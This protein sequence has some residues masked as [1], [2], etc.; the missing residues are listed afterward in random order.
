MSPYA[1]VLLVALGGLL[2]VLC[3]KAF[4]AVRPIS[5]SPTHLVLCAVFGVAAMGL[6][7]GPWIDGLEYEDA[8]IHKAFAR[9]LAA[10][11]FSQTEGFFVEVC[12]VGSFHD[13]YSRATFGTQLIGLGVID[14]V[15]VWLFGPHEWTT[16]YASAGAT[17]LSLLLVDQLAIRG[18]ASVHGRF[19]ALLC[20]IL[21]P[22]FFVI[23]ASSFAEPVFVFFILLQIFAY[24]KI[25][26]LRAL[27]MDLGWICIFLF[28]SILL[29]CTK[30]E[31]LTVIL[32][33]IVWSLAGV[34]RSRQMTVRSFLV[35]LRADP[36]S[37]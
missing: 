36:R 37:C 22:G 34:I 19:C 30:K 4:A 25:D 23:G 21:C 15:V 28:A 35:L 11:N 13:C 14:A 20:A 31:A 6:F 7:W 18:G 32:V 33:E 29:V 12:M 8:F 17:L 5:L 9:G 24:Y 26:D 2:L 16:N 27:R 3:L 10:S 1:A